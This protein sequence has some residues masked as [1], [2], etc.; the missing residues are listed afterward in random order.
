MS[1]PIVDTITSWALA[2]LIIGIYAAMQHLDAPADHRAEWAASA[3][4]QDAIKN[5]AARAR[6]AKAASEMCGNADFVEVDA[7]T[8][9]CIPRHGKGLGGAV[10][11]AGVTP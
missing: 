9:Q 7:T 5:E 1:R 8:I 6:F 11:V 10:Q 2:L 3:A 4:A